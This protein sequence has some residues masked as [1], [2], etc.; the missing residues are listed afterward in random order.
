MYAHQNAR[1]FPDWYKPY[2]FNYM[3]DGWLVFILLGFSIGGYSYFNDIKAE[4]G[5]KKRKVYMN[6]HDDL[7]TWNDNSTYHFARDRIAKG[8]PHWVKFTVHKPRAA[9]HH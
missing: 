1:V 5:R 3:G 8:D 6:M 4:K 9:L 7:K 2:G